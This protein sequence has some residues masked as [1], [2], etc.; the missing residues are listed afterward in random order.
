[1]MRLTYAFTIIGMITCLLPGIAAISL[2][3]LWLL[4]KVVSAV[5][6]TIGW[7]GP[8]THFMILSHQEKLR[9]KEEFEREQRKKRREQIGSEH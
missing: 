4:D 7:L 5:L 8:V 9:L 2:G 6:R 1:M 3:A